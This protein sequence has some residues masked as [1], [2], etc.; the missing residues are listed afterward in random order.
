MTKSLSVSIVDIFCRQKVLE[1]N[2]RP[3]VT[4]TVRSKYLGDL[5]GSVRPDWNQKDP[6]PQLI[7]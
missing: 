3:F 2:W 1:E 6:P 5:I 7:L 4:S